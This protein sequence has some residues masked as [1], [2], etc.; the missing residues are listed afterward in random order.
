[1]QMVPKLYSNFVQ[2]YQQN[3]TF[4]EGRPFLLGESLCFTILVFEIG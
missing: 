3:I 1:M 4:W 2:N